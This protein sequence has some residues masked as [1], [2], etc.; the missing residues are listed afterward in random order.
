[1]TN[2]CRI[3]LAHYERKREREQCLRSAHSKIG[4]DEKVKRPRTTRTAMYEKAVSPSLLSVCRSPIEHMYERCSRRNYEFKDVTCSRHRH[5][6]DCRRYMNTG[7]AR[8]RWVSPRV[9]N[10]LTIRVLRCKFELCWHKAHQT[11]RFGRCCDE[12]WPTITSAHWI[13]KNRM[14]RTHDDDYYYY[15]LLFP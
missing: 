7:D 14:Y 10:T 9:C 2:Y 1:M 12:R 4:N 15:Y 13:N 3:G 11:K 8:W 6:N 5:R